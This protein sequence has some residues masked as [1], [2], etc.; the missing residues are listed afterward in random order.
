MIVSKKIL[1]AAVLTLASAMSWADGKVVVLDPTGAVLATNV[2][3]AKFDK[4]AKSADFS[5]AKAKLDATRS[6]HK[7][8]VESYQ[9][10]AMTWSEEKRSE[11]EKKVQSLEQDITFQTKKLQ[12]AQQDV[13]QEVMK[14]LGPKLEAVVKQLV[15][16]EKIG[17]IVDAKAVMMAKPEY[18]LTPKV[19]EQLNKAK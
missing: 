18:D 8:L 4:L 13:A 9:K 5:A 6:D 3:K 19:T 17:M 12:A 15:E 11:T 1:L 16:S 10:D 14:E 7:A 2:A